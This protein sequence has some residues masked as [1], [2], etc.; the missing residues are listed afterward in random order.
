MGRGGTGWIM[1]F[2]GAL[3]VVVVVAALS[4]SLL[5]GCSSDDEDTSPPLVGTWV[6]ED[7]D[8]VGVL[9]LKADGTCLYEAGDSRDDLS[10]Y[11]ACTYEADESTLTYL[12]SSYCADSTDK[13]TY[14]YT[15]TNDQIEFKNTSG[16]DK[17][18]PRKSVMEGAIWTRETTSPSSSAS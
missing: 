9:Q 17:C 18:E 16:D 7:S 3:G 1:K 11:D 13:A 10:G 6:V 5:V 14:T 12:T 4:G 8:G 15:V 2:S